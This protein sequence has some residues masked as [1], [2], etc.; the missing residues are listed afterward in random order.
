[1]PPIAGAGIAAQLGRF[2][3]AMQQRP[4]PLRVVQPTTDFISHLGLLAPGAGLS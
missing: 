1:M 2:L 4:P 3:T